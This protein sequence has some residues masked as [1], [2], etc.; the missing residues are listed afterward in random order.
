MAKR[1]TIIGGGPGGYVA[2]IRA[3]QLGAHVHLVEMGALGGTC[4]N[5]GCIPTKAILHVAEIYQGLLQ[6]QTLGIRADNPGFDWPTV[7]KYKDSL[8]NRLVQG[9]D[10]L[11]K[12][13]KVQVHRG[14]ARLQ[15]A[16]LIDI[17]GSRH[18]TDVTILA[19]GSQPSR[20]SFPGANL[21]GI[22]DSSAALALK[23]PPKSMLVVGGGVIGVEFASMYHA[24]GTDVTIVEMLPQI[25]PGLDGE[26]V[27]LVQRDLL[28]RGIGILTDARLQEVR[29]HDQDLLACISHQG[30]TKELA[31]EKIL[32]AVGRRPCTKEMG[33]AEL[34]VAMDRD[35]IL[36]DD[37]F[38]TNLPN[39]YAIGD[40]SSVMMLAHVASAQGIAAVEHAMGHKGVYR[41]DI[42]PACIYTQPEI[43]S[44]GL[45]EEQAQKKGL[46]V[47]VGRFSLAGNGKAL[48]DSQGKG[49]I[50][51][52]SGAK[53]REI[54]GVHIWGPRATDLI[55]EAALAM[56][57]EATV[58][59]LISTVHAHPTVSEA[60]AEAAL[61]TDGL[62]LHWPPGLIP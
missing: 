20:L 57:L 32:V 26:I 2:A 52:I 39:V 58:D 25:L 31:A 15:S 9:V 42:V 16:N 19:T 46:D 50:K 24:L 53:Y 4:L 54:I 60:I 28:E 35:R 36:V 27:Q 30:Q 59:E 48:I 40:C 7:L 12:A 62:A 38:L 8:V 21:D 55:G 11:L 56:R 17:D 10:G 47:Q 33:L 29:S 44:V 37:N 61:A 34:G 5:L 22:I 43:A 49:L 45:T 23:N 13:N 6:S 3:A 14:H 41:A 1:I 51:I 18:E